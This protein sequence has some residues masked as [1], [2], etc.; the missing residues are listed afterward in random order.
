MMPK[1]RFSKKNII[2]ARNCQF[3][4]TKTVPNYKDTQA[5]EK[6]LTERGK[7]LAQTKTGICAKHQRFLTVE[8]KRARHIALLPFV[9][10]A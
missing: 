9:V 2:V 1:K 8:I 4:N 6:Y 5:L 3:C 7:I 10:R